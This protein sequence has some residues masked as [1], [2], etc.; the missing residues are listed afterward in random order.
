MKGNAPSDGFARLYLY[1]H[2]ID[3]FN[4]TGYLL[5]KNGQ[6]MAVERHYKNG[7]E[8]G[9]LDIIGVVNAKGLQEF[10]VHVVD[11]FTNDIIQLTDRTEGATGLMIQAITSEEKTGHGLLQFENDTS[12][13]I[14]F[15]SHYLGVDRMSLDWI[16]S[17][18]E[19]PVA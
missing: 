18:P 17:R 5:D 3:P 8:L 14:E 16:N 2:S 15:S 1:N 4:P 13:N 10:T 9:I 7:Q 11:S 6:P 19:A 12:Q